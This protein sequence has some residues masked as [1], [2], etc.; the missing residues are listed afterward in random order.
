M[1][2]LIFHSSS[3]ESLIVVIYFISF[4][5]GEGHIVKDSVLKSSARTDFIGLN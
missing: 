2:G 5:L 3:F 4:C 1:V